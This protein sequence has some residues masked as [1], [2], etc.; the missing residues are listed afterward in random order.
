MIAHEKERENYVGAVTPLS[1]VT[2][3]GEAFSVSPA[4][5]FIERLT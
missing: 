3:V 5:N 2:T 4:D 1:D